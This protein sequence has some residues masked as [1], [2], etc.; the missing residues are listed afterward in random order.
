LAVEAL[1]D[2]LKTGSSTAR[3]TAARIASSET[4]LPRSSWSVRG[5]YDE[6]EVARQEA[7]PRARKRLARLV[8]REAPAKADAVTAEKLTERDQP[9]LRSGASGRAAGRRNAGLVWARLALAIRSSYAPSFVVCSGGR[10]GSV[11]RDLLHHLARRAVIALPCDI[12]L[13][14][15]SDERFALDHGQP[16]NL[17]L[18]QN[19]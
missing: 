8:E 1:G 7:L 9:G 3:A 19:L 13:R 17:L 2:L 4:R 16:S 15:Y 18:G 5:F 10:P 14:N 6:Q 11:L 12:G